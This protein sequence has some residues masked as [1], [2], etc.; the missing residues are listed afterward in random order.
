MR[1]SRA[2]RAL[3]ETQKFSCADSFRGN[4]YIYKKAEPEAAD[5]LHELAVGCN[6]AGHGRAGERLVGVA[7]AQSRRASAI[8][9]RSAHENFGVF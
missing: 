3:Y 4:I 5:R 7:Y 9:W 6:E 8:S 2:W 1:N